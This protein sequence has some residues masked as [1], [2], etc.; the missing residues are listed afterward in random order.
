MMVDVRRDSELGWKVIDAA[1]IVI[2]VLDEHGAIQYFNPYLERL[3]GYRLDELRG[4]DWFETFLP[5][6]DHARI[7]KLFDL[8]YGGQPVRGNIN[9]IV[10]R[11][12]EERQIEWVDDVLIDTEGVVQGLLAIGQD[13][14]ERD[15][16][17]RNLQKTKQRLAEAQ[18][19]ANVGSWEV[20]LT[21]GSRWWSEQMYRMT[22]IPV[23]R[24][25]VE[26]TFRQTLH[27]D[28]R[29]M[30]DEVFRSALVTG[31]A[32]GEFRV[33]RPDGSAR[34]ILSRATATYEDGRPTKLSG[35]N[36]DITA[37]K[38]AEHDLEA[39]LAAEAKLVG[40]LRI[41]DRRKDE[42][43][44]TLSHELRNPLS[45]IQ[46]SVRVLDEAG[47]EA[48]TAARML[49][50]IGRQVGYLTRLV[51]ELLDVSRIT[52]KKIQLRLDSVDLV[53]LLQAVVEDYRPSFDRSGV[54]LE[55]VGIPGAAVVV[56]DPARLA[57]V[58]G[59]LLH[60][61]EKFTPRGGRVRVSLEIA[62][63]ERQAV[64]RVS[65]TGA[66]IEPAM[67]DRVFEPFTQADRTLARSLGG[68]GLG[69]AVVKGLVGLHGGTVSVRSGGAQQGAEFVV[70]LPL[71]RPASRPAPAES[72]PHAPAE[73]RR[74]LIIEDNADVAEAL[75]RILEI[76]GHR[77]DCAF[78]GSRGIEMARE[79][80]PDVV[81][82][83]LGLPQVSGYDVARA[84][85]ADETLRSTLL[86]AVSGYAA[87]E[88]IARARAAGFDDHI[89]K[90]VDITHLRQALAHAKTG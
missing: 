3:T 37:R 38:Q 83:D 73:P 88:D 74:V 67:L 18:R 87:Q 29:E 40:Q 58:M 1:P 28:D 62:E 53:E 25:I 70:R 54:S 31:A 78:D 30:F 24:R 32:E 48:D 49:D 21:T 5:E 47:H 34:V 26:G 59:N 90:P 39:S 15:A 56:G 8:S 45:A 41:A 82:C 35:T 36:Q 60:N 86:V 72:R 80:R 65:D 44:A 57:Q 20:D 17:Q 63:T 42:F 19:I 2:L 23:G 22:G 33:I 10:T 76:D 51:D 64:L 4:K 81:L 55:L 16:A 11:A 46:S 43:I 77:V 27:P 50:I 84:L 75:R 89:R 9:P 68:L 52:Q 14:T 13:V 12:G 85:R 7:R 6:R 69:L 66:G 61:A 79:L 71:G